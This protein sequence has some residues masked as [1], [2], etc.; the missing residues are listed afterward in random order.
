MRNGQ[1]DTGCFS[2]L[3]VLMVDDDNFQI[4][5]MR[6]V[7]TELGVQPDCV[8]TACGGVD[9]LRKLKV[10]AVP[11]LLICDLHMPGMDGF[12]FMES[13]ASLGLDNSILIVSGQS[14]D[15]RYSAGLVAKLRRLKFL[16]A[17]EKPVASAALKGVLLEVMKHRSSLRG[18]AT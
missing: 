2:T 15:I 6:E 18:V 5:L 14:S 3:R 8:Q 7:L 1:M 16:G 9:A 13:V 10:G 12:Q 11:D 4:E 17:L